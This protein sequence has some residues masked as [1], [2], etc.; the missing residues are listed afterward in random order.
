M[1]FIEEIATYVIKYAP[2]YGIKVYSPIIAQAILESQMG[3]SN[4]VY[5]N[6]EWRHNYFGLKW[7]NNRCAISNDY[8]EEWTAEQN[9]DG[10]YKNIV[11]KFC[12]FK[13]LEDCVIGY[14]Q[15]TNTS[16]YSNLK[17]VTDP[18]I[19]LENIKKDKYAT[20]INYVE[21]LMNVIKKYDLAKYDPQP[22]S[23]K[24]YRVQ[25]G[26]FKSEINAKRLQ[27]QIKSAGFPVIIKKVGNLYK[28]Q[29]GAFN[30]KVNA[31]DLLQSV[32]SKGFDAFLIYQ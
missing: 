32:K 28:C 1:T 12:K 21:N 25:V 19:Y 30:N 31:E 6:G 24:Y 14:F 11:S 20:S 7:R 9:V 8:F 3:K 23:Q 17:G 29:L 22:E 5:N 15:W 16:T 10:T 26:A 13:S 4:K 2:Q 18:R 27:A